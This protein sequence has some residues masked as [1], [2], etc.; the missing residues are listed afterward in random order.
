MT[1]TI[2]NIGDH[3]MSRNAVGPTPDRRL[4]R[5]QGLCTPQRQR[6][7]RKVQPFLQADIEQHAIS[8]LPS[9]KA[10]LRTHGI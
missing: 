1:R 6:G 4:L 3:G 10:P 2:R 7:N 9:G 8:E 5:H